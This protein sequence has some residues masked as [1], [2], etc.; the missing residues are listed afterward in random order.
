MRLLVVGSVAF[1]AVRTPRGSVERMVG[2]SA[3]YFSVAASYF[4]Q[5]RVVGVVGDD[6]EDEHHQVFLERGICTEGLERVPGKTFFWSGEY[7]ADLNDR[8]TLATELNVFAS[9]QPKLPLHYRRTPYLF[10]G[11]IDPE[12]QSLVQRQM[13]APQLVAGD[14]MN[15]WIE[16]KRDK[17]EETLRNIGVLIINDSEA[18]LLSGEH[19]LI[20]A[21]RAIRAMGPQMLVIKRG[22][23]GATLFREGEIFSVPALPLEDVFDPTGAGDSFAG[24]FMGYLASHSIEGNGPDPGVLR[25]AVIYGSV[26]GS[27]AVEHFGLERLRRLSRPQI[28]TRYKEFQILTRFD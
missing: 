25:R 4:T 19:N 12:L 21:A 17:L 3:T 6:F 5:V 26:M 23:N 1:D 11:N 10:L 8:R 13:E 2:G 24:G 28:E 15:F 16:G 7:S 22:D 9:F 18:R 27:F 14:T 20:K